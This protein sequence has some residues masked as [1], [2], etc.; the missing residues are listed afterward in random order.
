MA[1][2]FFYEKY[3]DVVNSMSGPMTKSSFQETGKLTPQ[4]FLESGDSLVQKF[5]AWEWAAGD[6]ETQPFLPKNKKYLILRQC[7]CPQRAPTMESAMPEGDA[8]DDWVDTHVGHKVQKVVVE[9]DAEEED[10]WAASDDDDAAAAPKAQAANSDLRL[11]DVTVVYDQYYA[12]PRVYLFGYD[13]NGQPLTK[14]QM[15]ADVYADN[16]EKTVTVDPHPFLKAPCISIH[17][18]RHAETMRRIIERAEVRMADEQ[19]EAGVPEAERIQFV[20]P[21]YLALFVFLKFIGSVV[22]TIMYDISVD[23]DM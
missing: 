17:P 18:C 6:E 19:E 3:K 20:F 9:E 7:P 2:R 12:S 10:D 5:P 4:E 22:P 8:G 13:A 11:Y 15:M 16:R 14:D 1:K 23:L 21:T